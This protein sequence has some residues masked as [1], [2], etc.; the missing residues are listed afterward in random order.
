MEVI[1]KYAKINLQISAVEKSPEHIIKNSQEV[2][3]VYSCILCLLTLCDILYGPQ[4][5]IG[6]L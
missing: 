1:F 4:L 5:S 6:I 2:N 3:T